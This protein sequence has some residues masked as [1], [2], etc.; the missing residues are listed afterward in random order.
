MKRVGT[1]NLPERTIKL[2]KAEPEN[3]IYRDVLKMNGKCIQIDII[4]PAHEFSVKLA[5]FY[6]IDGEATSFPVE[7]FDNIE[8][9]PNMGHSGLHKEFFRNRGQLYTN[10]YGRTPSKIND[11]MKV[12]REDFPTIK[13]NDMEVVIYGGERKA[14]I[15]GVRFNIP[16]D[17]NIPKDYF[18]WNS[19]DNMDEIV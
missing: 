2:L 4:N 15:M 13:D 1:L 12:I 16:K 8:K 11:F 18:E 7:F 9:T 6:T 14:R 5:N 3:T 19:Y 17:V 10:N